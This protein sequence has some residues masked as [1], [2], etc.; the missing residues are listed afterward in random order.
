MEAQHG[1]S[2]EAHEVTAP[3]VIAA[4]AGIWQMTQGPARAGP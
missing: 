4:K 1:I 2:G 3:A